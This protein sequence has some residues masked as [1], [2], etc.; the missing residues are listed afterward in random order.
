MENHALFYSVWDA[1]NKIDHVYAVGMATMLYLIH[2][3]RIKICL[4]KLFSVHKQENIHKQSYDENDSPNS[5]FRIL[6]HVC[7]V[8]L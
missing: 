4:C 6:S 8:A 3:T 7:Y 2:C 5:V 1:A